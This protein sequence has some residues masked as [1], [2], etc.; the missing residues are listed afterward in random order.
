MKKKRSESF[1]SHKKGD[2]ELTNARFLVTKQREEE[3]KEL[4]EKGGTFR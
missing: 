3:R 4:S 1:I 2:F